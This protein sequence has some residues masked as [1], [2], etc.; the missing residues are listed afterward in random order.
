MKKK[1]SLLLILILIFTVPL[2]GC[3]K[4][5]EVKEPEEKVISVE[6]K[7][8]QK[9]DINL[10]T[11]L[12]AKV[13]P[14]EEASVVPKIPGKVAKINIE[15][16]QKVNKGDVLFTLD[17]T[18]MLNVVKNAEAAY[19]MAVANLKIREEQIENARTNYERMKFLYEQGAISKQQFE[20]YELQASSTNLEVAKAQVEQSR[21]AL[22][23]A[24]S[25]LVDTTVTSPISGVI[26]AV[27]INEGEM[28]SSAMPAVSI[29]N[30]D[31][32]VIETD[33][34]EYLINKVKIGDSVDISIKSAGKENFKGKITALSPATSQGSMTYPIKI[35]IDNKNKLIKPGMFGEV[36][37]V[38]EK[39]EKVITV[40]SEAVI[41][42][43]GNDV[44][45][46]VED[47]KAHM[48]NVSLGI[49]NGEYVEIIKG[50]KEGETV[51]IKGQ[52]YLDEGSKV[53]TAK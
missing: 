51:V 50:V 31:K 52:N 2:A 49:D 7:K 53:K 18:D 43:E 28:A 32:V 17:K 8:V 23:N 37:I 6:T 15:I 41:V 5:K 27:N 21:V 29:A 48:K 34:S 40:P 30:L 39:K 35:E 9:G 22:E 4:K 3:K 12:S 42:K 38:T 19:N 47:N 33:I 44:V 13:A 26:T 46:T 20:Q 14:I 10:K 36:S 25:S 11:T 1:I 16:G 45:F 24:K